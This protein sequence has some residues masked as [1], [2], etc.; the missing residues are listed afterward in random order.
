MAEVLAVSLPAA[1]FNGVPRASCVCPARWFDR[2]FQRLM[3]THGRIFILALFAL[4]SANTA[5]PE[6]AAPPRATD[7]PTGLQMS[8]ATRMPHTSTGM[9]FGMPLSAE[10][11]IDNQ[12]SVKLQPSDGSILH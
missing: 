11:A 6:F 9:Q 10:P 1:C 8:A 3:L 2:P 5:A 7:A 12:A 4:W